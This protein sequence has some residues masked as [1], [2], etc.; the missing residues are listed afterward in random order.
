MN[1]GLERRN[2]EL[3]KRVA[4]E[5]YRHTMVHLERKNDLE[6]KN[7]ELRQVTQK[8]ERLSGL[9]RWRLLCEA[10]LMAELVRSFICDLGISL[11]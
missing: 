6:R 2:K 3:V 5:L 9:V 1:K 10:F 4:E 8:V 7:F 11:F